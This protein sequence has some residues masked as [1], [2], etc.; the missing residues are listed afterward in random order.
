MDKLFL[1]VAGMPII[2]H[3]W[4][5]FDRSPSVDHVVLVIRE[6]R[7][8][9]FEKLALRV[10]PTKPWTLT[11]GGEERQD[12]VWNGL[13][14]VP[15]ET[16]IVLIQ[17]GA[18]PCTPFSLIQNLVEAADR[19]GAAVAASHVT[20]T[21]KTSESGDFITSHLERSKLHA[22]QTPQTFR[23]GVIQKALSAV[24]EQNL[25]ITDDTAACE[26]IGQPVRL[27]HCDQPNPKATAPSDL[28]YLELLLREETV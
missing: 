22:V 28:P 9:E 11:P 27:V 23:L 20:D 10:N 3:T 5:R 8:E 17:D 13:M 18:R 15:S 26:F 16:R 19:D 12:S 6:E 21:I 1:E 24:R 2:G 14:A 7:R 4:R 25:L